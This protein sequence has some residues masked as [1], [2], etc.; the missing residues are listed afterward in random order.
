[1]QTIRSFSSSH[2]NNGLIAYTKLRRTKKDLETSERIDKPKRILQETG[3]ISIPQGISVVHIEILP[4]LSIAEPDSQSTK[5]RIRNKNI[6]Q[7]KMSVHVANRT[8]L[9]TFM[10]E[11]LV[12]WSIF[13]ISTSRCSSIESLWNNIHDD[14]T[15]G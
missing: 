9:F 6:S 3:E 8:K 10:S 5:K 1:V 14:F 11:S 2:T 15:S 7:K 12:A 13:M 4:H